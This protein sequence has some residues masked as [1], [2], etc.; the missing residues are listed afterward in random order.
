MKVE[1]DSYFFKKKIK[2]IDRSSR[3]GRKRS[4]MKRRGISRCV[5]KCNTL[6]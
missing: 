3:M 5:G 4:T 6:N 1:G 2:W